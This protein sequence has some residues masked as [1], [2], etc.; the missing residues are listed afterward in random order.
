M[1][2]ASHC[3][4]MSSTIARVDG[5]A[6]NNSVT[7][8]WLTRFLPF[9]WQNGNHRPT[10]R[11]WN[12]I[13]IRVLAK[14][15]LVSSSQVLQ[16]NKNQLVSKTIVQDLLK[17]TINCSHHMVSD[18]GVI[19]WDWSTQSNHIISADPWAQ[20]LFFKM[21]LKWSPIRIWWRRVV[22]E[23]LVAKHGPW[24]GPLGLKW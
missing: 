16:W 14:Y 2:T 24:W 10:L 9:C 3:I 17:N 13:S 20:W 23:I 1:Y 4:R 15:G 12:P 21:L 11:W 19:L 5:L 8:Q 7:N 22:T 6:G 18:T